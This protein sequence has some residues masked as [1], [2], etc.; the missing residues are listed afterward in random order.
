MTSQVLSQ[1]SSPEVAAPEARPFKKAIALIAHDRI[2]YFER[3]LHSICRQ[4]VLGQSIFEIYDFY[5]FQDGIG[6]ADEARVKAHAAITELSKNTQSVKQ[7]IVQPI[8]LGVGKHFAFVEDYLFNHGNHDFVVFCEDD[9]VLG[10]AYMTTLNAMA[11]KFYDDER[12]AM[13]SAH[14]QAYKATSAEQAG[15]IQDY[16]PMGHSWGFGL[17]KRA[18]LAIQPIVE[19]YLELLGQVPYQQR[20]HTAIQFWQQQC[21]LRAGATS[22]D[23]IKS[24]ALVALG[25][26]RLSSYPNYGLYIGEEGV[27]FNAQT[28]A[29][30]RYADTV[31][32]DQPVLEPLPLDAQMYQKLWG[33]MANQCL[34]DPQQFKVQEFRDLL[35]K[36]LSKPTFPNNLLTSL[37]TAE[38]VIAI[39]KLLLNRLPKSQQQIDERV[40]LPMDQLFK[41]SIDSEEFVGRHQYWPAIIMLTRKIMKEYESE[42]KKTG[43]LPDQ[44]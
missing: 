11:N 1:T 8:N 36:G 28:Y 7:F 14:S 38:D 34:Q 39:D 18:W 35:A 21:G 12:V 30:H 9:M 44:Q 20:N 6:D 33:P 27:H 10:D 2:D 22:Q 4:H 5:I 15:R 26:L 29:K 41:D 23:Y 40:G 32:F 3:T 37:S 13:L 42:Q 19:V 24:C 43:E 17:Y 16:L 25:Y 31:V